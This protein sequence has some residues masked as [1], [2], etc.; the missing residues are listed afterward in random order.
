MLSL[1]YPGRR[2][3]MMGENAETGFE[4]IVAPEGEIK[5]VFVNGQIIIIRNGEKF[6]I[7]GQRL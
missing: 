6:N 2:R 7:Q 5:K 1:L 3:V 4:N